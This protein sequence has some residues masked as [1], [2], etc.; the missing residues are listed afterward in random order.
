MTASALAEAVAVLRRGGVVCMPTETSYG[1]A[2]DIRSP[3]AL[4][5]LCRIKGRDARA[6]PFGLIV[7]EPAQ[8]R[9]LARVWPERA[10]ALAQRYWPGP[11]TLVVPAAAGLPAEIIGPDGGVGMRVS[12][13]PLALALAR[14]LGAP[15]TATS[16]NPS[17]QPPAMDTARARAYFGD[18]VAYL[19]AGPAPGERASTVVAIAADGSVAVLRAGPIDVS[20]D[21]EA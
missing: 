14:A 15:I 11:L 18:A 16:A 9:G 6:A 2:A 8:A 12:S 5:C 13:H 4:A 19:D 20:A 7:A 17:G 1:L 10:E 21:M 3:D